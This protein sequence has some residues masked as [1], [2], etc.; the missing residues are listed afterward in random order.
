[1]ADIKTA[2]QYAYD[3]PNTDFA[4]ELQ[5]RIQSGALNTELETAGLKK[6]AD[7]AL[8][9]FAQGVAKGELS[10]VKETG[11]LLQ[12]LGQNILAGITT[13]A[14]KLIGKDT[15]FAQEKANIKATTGFK[16]LQKGT[17]EEQRAREFLTPKTTAEKVGFTTEKVAE[18]FVPASK[19]QKAQSSL[20]ILV[21]GSKLPSYAKVATKVLGKA[22][23]EGAGVG[24]V[25]LAQTGDIKEA[26]KT[27]LTAGVIKTGTGVVGETL[28]KVKIPERLYSRIFKESSDDAIS[29]IRSEVASG[30][31]Q[32]NPTKYAEYV[33]KGI[34]NPTTKAVNETLAKE[35]L[36]RGL[37]GSISNMAKKTVENTWDLENSARN[38]VAGKTVKISGSKALV[39]T[40]KSTADDWSG[41]AGN[42]VTKQANKYAKLVS[43]GKMSGEDALS[44]RRFLDG[45]RVKSSFNPSAKRSLGQENYKFYAD[46]MRGALAKLPGM[47]S[48]M[49]DY[50]FNIEAL[51][52]LGKEAARTNNRQVLG[53]IDSIFIGQG[54]AM[55][56][57]VAST[58]LALTRRALGGAPLSTRIAQTIQKSGVST[59]AGIATKG[60]IGQ[61]F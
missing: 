7:S 53:L 61:E 56:A 34:I 40:L 1:M 43:T 57:P 24:A 48:I 26:G 46:K 28:K 45:L 23:I 58:A 13:G 41:V 42:T 19:I 52:A 8:S 51:E 12:G 38:A 3:N 49:N 47:K 29:A 31:E 44:L 39:D 2:I 50:R 15:T 33:S 11:G 22:G 27:A 30:L 16:T 10:T 21:N 35:A 6:K 9:Q 25:T 60:L 5:S 14:K 18:F 59:K 54:I 36:D 32:T 55:G 20:D 4:K 17:V 37:K